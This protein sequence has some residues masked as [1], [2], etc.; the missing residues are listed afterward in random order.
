[1]GKSLRIL[2]LASLLS[3]FSI[4]DT[5]GSNVI[6]FGNDWKTI[7]DY[8]SPNKYLTCGEQSKLNSENIKFIKENI[9][10][11]KNDYIGIVKILMFKQKYFT[12]EGDGGAD[13]GKATINDLIRNKKLSGCH[14]HALITAGILR[15]FGYPVIMVDCADIEW[16]DK[17][18]N[19][20]VSNFVGH[21]LLEVYLNDK[22]IL[23]DPTGGFFSTIY[24][25]DNPVIKTQIQNS[26]ASL[27]VMFK[28]LD[29]N[30]YGIYENKELQ[31][32][33]K[34]FSNN[35]NTIRHDGNVYYYT[36][37]MDYYRENSGLFGNKYKFNLTIN[38]KYSGKI[39]IGSTYKILIQ[40]DRYENGYPLIN[41]KVDKKEGS[42]TF[43]DVISDVD[44][45]YLIGWAIK[46][47]SGH[48]EKGDPTLRQYDA[49]KKL[50]PVD[51]SSGLIMI[52]AEFDDS[53]LWQMN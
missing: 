28:G 10:I 25:H 51:I 8:S 19:H 3:C 17:F 27:Y 11:E 13:I 31:D 26:S 18:K 21:V 49:N 7:I 38:Y 2:M 42:V 33:L 37:Y 35:I 52:N 12:I 15:L 5:S 34:L 23:L 47:S 16:V 41:K 45:I 30:E 9:A 43:K 32:N 24:D 39:E 20:Q 14:D 1:M 48:S 22:W 29:T 44:S 36:Y 46:D 53:I 40:L 50:I 6:L 4:Y